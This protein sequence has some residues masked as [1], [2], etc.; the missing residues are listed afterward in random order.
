MSL[1]CFLHHPQSPFR[2][3]KPPPVNNPEDKL[4]SST[5]TNSKTSMA[6]SSGHPND[7]G[8]KAATT[9]DSSSSD[10]DGAR[11]APPKARGKNLALQSRFGQGKQV[12]LGAPSADDSSEDSSDSSIDRKE[13]AHSVPTTGRGKILT[14][15]NLR[16]VLPTAQNRSTK[17]VPRDVGQCVY[18]D[19]FSIFAR[20]TLP[21]AEEFDEIM[22]AVKSVTTKL[23]SQRSGSTNRM[24]QL[25]SE[26]SS[27]NTKRQ[28]FPSSST[29][30]N[31][32]I[33]EDGLS[34]QSTYDVSF[35]NPHHIETIAPNPKLLQHALPRNEDMKKS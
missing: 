33:G 18:F 2:A 22:A 8:K 25:N 15:K 20:Q 14:G 34:S 13:S 24:S 29:I 30:F 26:V 16:R 23:T 7:D 4:H 11:P 27:W 9:D 10:D 32:S 19:V 21:S 35:V 3:S 5:A 17:S 6:D 28:I 1:K 31:D 12:R